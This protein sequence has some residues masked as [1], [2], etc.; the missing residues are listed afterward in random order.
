MIGWSEVLVDAEVC[1]GAGTGVL[2]RMGWSLEEHA[3]VPDVL[4][5]SGIAGDDL[6][7]LAAVV[8]EDIL[9]F[10]CGVSDGSSRAEEVF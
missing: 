1:A 10:F 9:S 8:G 6:P 4:V 7:E 5:A 3:P 2:R